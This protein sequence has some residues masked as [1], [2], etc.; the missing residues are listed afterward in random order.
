MRLLDFFKKKKTDDKV[1]DLDKTVVMPSVSDSD[2]VMEKQQRLEAL[3]NTI[4]NSNELEN[5]NLEEELTK[6]AYEAMGLSDEEINKRLGMTEEDLNRYYEEL[7]AQKKDEINKKNE[8]EI[9]KA[10]VA[11]DIKRQRARGKLETEEEISDYC[12]EK[13]IAFKSGTFEYPSEVVEPIRMRIE[14]SDMVAALNGDETK[15]KK[16]ESEKDVVL[17]YKQMIK[18]ADMEK[19]VVIKL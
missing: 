6:R 4:D 13:M 17:R 14:N 3:R 9:F 11:L 16:F 12:R 1:E 15:L 7:D 19:T 10:C 8:M 2:T 18:E 5:I